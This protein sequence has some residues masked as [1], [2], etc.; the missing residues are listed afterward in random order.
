[1][2]NIEETEKAK[3]VVAEDRKVRPKTNNDE[4]H[5]AASRCKSSGVIFRHSKSLSHPSV[6]RPNLKQKSDADILRDAKLEAMGLPPQEE[7][8][9]NY[10]NGGTQMA[11]DEAVCMLV[12]VL[13]IILIGLV[14][15]GAFQ[16]ED[17][18]VTSVFSL[19]H[20]KYI[21]IQPTSLTMTSCIVSCTGPPV[22]S[23]GKHNA[24][25]RRSQ[26]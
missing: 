6:Y 18:Q 25:I 1:L 5:L 13:L 11:T 3:R 16:E 4:E 21:S 10:N 24:T 12:Y 2:K 19:I 17:A 15:D 14:G 8:R 20:Y 7:T 22:C 9:R 26:T 23:A